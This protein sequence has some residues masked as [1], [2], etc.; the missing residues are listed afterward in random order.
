[1]EQKPPAS[2][3]A[4]PDDDEDPYGSENGEEEKKIT[5]LKLRVFI[6]IDE[7]DNDTEGKNLDLNNLFKRVDPKLSFYKDVR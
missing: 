4:I 1:M 3:A 2:N 7:D 6:N 5:V